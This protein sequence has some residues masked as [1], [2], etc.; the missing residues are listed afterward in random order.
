MRE[1]GP[2]DQLLGTLG[3][4]LGALAA[5]PVARRRAPAAAQDSLSEPARREAAGLMRVNHAGEVAAQALYQGQA[6]F[7]RDAGTRDFLHRA[8]AEEQDHL[9]WCEERL[10]ELGSQPS[11]L[12][13]LWY[14]GS[15]AIGTIAGLAGDRVSL[16]FVRETESQVEA[17]LHGH[18]ER[19]P[20]DDHR[21]RSIVAAMCSD[22]AAHGA[23][24]AA[25]GGIELP[26][27]VQSLMRAA[28]RV[29]TSTAYWL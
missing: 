25:A 18:L 9:A 19:L 14:A 16:G 5:P 26:A 29:M 1:L 6:L 15:F 27:P 10:H 8:A 11:L 22:E 4:A 7:A 24:A 3:Q 23:N 13:P 28:A 2:L 20:A 12:K 17:H 21:S